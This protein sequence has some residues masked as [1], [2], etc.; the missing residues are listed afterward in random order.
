MNNFLSQCHQPPSARKF[1]PVPL[2]VLRSPTSLFCECLSGDTHSPRASAH[3]PAGVQNQMNDEQRVSS[4]H[5][6]YANLQGRWDSTHMKM[7]AT[8]RQCMWNVTEWIKV[9]ETPGFP[10]GPLHSWGKWEWLQRKWVLREILKA[11]SQFWYIPSSMLSLSRRK[12]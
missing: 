12:G 4:K 2:K 9:R 11:G 8:I 6:G 1:S 10:Q 3:D 5:V 7:P